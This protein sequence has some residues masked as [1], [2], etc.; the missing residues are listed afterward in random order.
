MMLSRINRFNSSCE[1][2]LPANDAV[3]KRGY[4]LKTAKFQKTIIKIQKMV[5]LS[6]RAAYFQMND[7][8]QCQE[9]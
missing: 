2:K 4:R 6:E 7:Q 9:A 3:E 8:L 1:F 5:E